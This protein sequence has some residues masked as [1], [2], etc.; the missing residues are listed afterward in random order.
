[1]SS[2]PHA[3]HMLD[4]YRS[5]F[6][7]LSL[8][9]VG[10]ASFRHLTR[11]IQSL[12]FPL[13]VQLLSLK[14]PMFFQVSFQTI[15]FFPSSFSI[16]RLL[17]LKFA[18]SISTI[19]KAILFTLL[20]ISLSILRFFHLSI[21]FVNLPH[22]SLNSNIEPSL[23]PFFARLSAMSFSKILLCPFTFLSCKSKFFTL[24]IF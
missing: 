16:Q 11:N 21:A 24:L 19:A 15:L 3:I 7:L 2:A 8:S 4:S 12:F 20:L 14:F 6:L 18:H 17:L 1:S 22:G 5:G 23:A 10:K 13:S 9:I